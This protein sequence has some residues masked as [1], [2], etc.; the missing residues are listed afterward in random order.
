MR[1][2]EYAQ[3]VVNA[4]QLGAL[5]SDILR[6]KALAL[7]MERAKITD[8]SGN[9]IDLNALTPAVDDPDELE[10]AEL[11]AAELDEAESSEAEVSDGAIDSEP[12]DGAPS[13]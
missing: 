1:A 12:G 10:T 11:E 8:A 3:Q 2:D 4:G 13:E 6:G 7:V 9:A 5:M